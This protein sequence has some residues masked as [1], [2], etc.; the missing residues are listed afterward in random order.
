ME[1]HHTFRLTRPLMKK[2]AARFWIAVGVVAIAIHAVFCVQAYIPLQ[3]G[4]MVSDGPWLSLY[5]PHYMLDFFLP[6][7]Y[8][9]SYSQSGVIHVDYLDFW[10]KMMVAFPASVAYALLP[11][12]IGVALVRLFKHSPGCQPPSAAISKNDLGI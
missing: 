5:Y 10:G 2:G 9:I 4:G 6:P 12:G 11:V 7:P 3:Q 8:P 1:S